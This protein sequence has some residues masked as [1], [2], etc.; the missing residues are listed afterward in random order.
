MS[1]WEN[2]RYEIGI[3]D[4]SLSFVSSLSGGCLALMVR[5]HKDSNL[6]HVDFILQEGCMTVKS[7]TENGSSER[8]VKPEFLDYMIEKGYFKSELGLSVRNNRGIVSEE[9]YSLLL[10]LFRGN[11]K[12]SLPVVYVTREDNSTK[13]PNVDVKRL[14]GAIRGMAYVV[15][16][17]STAI[18][19]MLQKDFYRKS[20]SDGRVIVIFPDGNHTSCL[21][22]RNVGKED[23]K[24]RFEFKIC[25]LVSKRMVTL[26]DNEEKSWNYISH[27]NSKECTDKKVKEYEDFESLCDDVLFLKEQE[28]S[29]RDEKIKDLEAEL[30]ALNRKVSY[31]EESFKKKDR[32]ETYTKG[33][34]LLCGE[35]EFYEGE[36]KDCI[37][38]IFEK[39]YNTMKGD[40]NNEGSR[41]FHLLASLLSVNEV[42]TRGRDFPKLL[43][44]VFS[45]C[46]FRSICSSRELRKLGFSVEE[47]SHSKVIFHGDRRY[48]FALSKTPSDVRALENASSVIINTLVC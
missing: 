22:S 17:S 21:P 31:Y 20:A 15:V 25:E 12:A 7:T 14:S 26:L 24:K 37:L 16:E 40:P 19:N 6:S 39:E 23:K 11:V 41:K 27:L 8:T 36:V 48:I 3:G 44:G 18:F 13:T 35:E 30:E 46:S 33:A 38:K 2:G 29:S 9:T 47:G 10:N 32:S 4:Y 42:S 28:V 34:N 1:N 45:N 5:E 43:K